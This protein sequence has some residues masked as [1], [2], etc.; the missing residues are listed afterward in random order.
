M[1]PTGFECSSWLA[2]LFRVILTSIRILLAASLLAFALQLTRTVSRRNSTGISTL[3]VLFNLISTTE[4]FALAFFYIVNH[5]EDPDFFV[6][7]PVN[8]GDWINLVQTNVVFILWLT[9]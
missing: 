2:P 1:C 6:H 9:L 3:Y 5:F 7:S 8:A 4:Q